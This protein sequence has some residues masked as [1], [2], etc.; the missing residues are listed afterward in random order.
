[1][2]LAYYVK[3]FVSLSII[4]G[5]LT[6]LSRLSKTFYQKK[7]S[8]SISVLDR[9]GLDVGVALLVVKIE[10]QKY[11]MSVGGKDVKLLKELDDSK[12][13]L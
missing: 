10:N 9:L 6:L 13:N 8:G 1:M 2:P 11:L 12:E 5:I 4:V 3:L 7:Y